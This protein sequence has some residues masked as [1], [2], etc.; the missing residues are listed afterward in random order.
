MLD[1]HAALAAE[2]ADLRQQLREERCAVSPR[3]ARLEQ[4]LRWALRC[5]AKEQM[6]RHWSR[7]GGVEMWA[8]ACDLCGLD[9][10][11]GKPVKG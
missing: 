6:P 7:C 3:E 1:S 11:T 4:A 9:P 2:I 8:H 5:M 10:E